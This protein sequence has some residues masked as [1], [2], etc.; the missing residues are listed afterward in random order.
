M[1]DSDRDA[2]QITSITVVDVGRVRGGEFNMGLSPGH[3]GNK[4][5]VQSSLNELVRHGKNT[6]HYA[7]LGEWCPLLLR[8]VALS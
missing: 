7:V 5:L 4:G 3:I 6:K 2:T 8:A 1:G